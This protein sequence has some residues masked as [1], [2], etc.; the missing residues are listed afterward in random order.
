MLIGQFLVPF[1]DDGSRLAMV[2]AV[3]ILRE[4]DLIARFE[5]AQAG[6]PNTAVGDQSSDHQSAD[7]LGFQ[8]F[9]QGG[10]FEGI[11]V[12]LV[13]QAVTRIQMKPGM[14]LPGLRSRRE[15]FLIGVLDHDD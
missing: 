6:R 5:R 1:R 3:P 7:L 12:H 14:K 13:H 10:G 8:D 4:H 11:A 9:I 2:V 15:Y